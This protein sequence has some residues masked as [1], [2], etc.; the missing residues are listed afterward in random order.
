MATKANYN[1]PI[2]HFVAP[3]IFPILHACVIDWGS[4][5][6]LKPPKEFDPLPLGG[7]YPSRG[8]VEE[9]QVRGV[10]YAACQAHRVGSIEP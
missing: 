7:P 2:E 1:L 8:G 10:V 4:D 3:Q 9:E 6:V 5:Y